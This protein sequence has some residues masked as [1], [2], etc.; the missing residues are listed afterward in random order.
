MID[1]TPFLCIFLMFILLF[2]AITIIMES[3]Y[4]DVDYKEVPK[5]FR[6]L[7]QTF[8]NSIGDI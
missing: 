5:T 2:T 7:I 1:L 3:D 6:V 8:R 4:E